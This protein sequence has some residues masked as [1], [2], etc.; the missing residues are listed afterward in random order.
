LNRVGNLLPALLFSP[1]FGHLQ[2]L[3]DMRYLEDIDPGGQ[4]G[5]FCSKARILVPNSDAGLIFA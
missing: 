2:F 1:H 5:I 4:Y 3:R